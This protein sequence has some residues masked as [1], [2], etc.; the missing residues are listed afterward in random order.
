MALIISFI[1][2]ADIYWHIWEYKERKRLD[3]CWNDLF[4]SKLD[5]DRRYIDLFKKIIYKEQDQ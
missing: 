5:A 3:E 4:N 2:G 1:I